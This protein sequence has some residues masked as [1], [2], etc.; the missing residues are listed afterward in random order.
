MAV[1]YASFI[2]QFPEFERSPDP[3]VIMT[4]IATAEHLVSDS[5]SLRTKDDFTAL[6]AADILAQGP[7]GR[8]A[9]LVDSKT[10]RTIYYMRLRD[11]KKRHGMA[12]SRTG[13]NRILGS[14][15]QQNFGYYYGYRR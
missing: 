3:S 12:R 9:R 5:W 13:T 15:Q 4:A 8:N 10:G 11:F 6:M 7:V 14:N 2:L 1:T